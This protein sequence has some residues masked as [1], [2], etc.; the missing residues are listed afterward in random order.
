MLVATN[1]KYTM[2]DSTGHKYLQQLLVKVKYFIWTFLRISL[3]CT[4]VSITQVTSTK[5][6]IRCTVQWNTNKMNTNTIT[7]LSDDKVKV[8][9]KVEERILQHWVSR[10]VITIAMYL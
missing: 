2:I 3:K 7:I 4:K 5:R 10:L 9:V 8:K 1:I 6:N